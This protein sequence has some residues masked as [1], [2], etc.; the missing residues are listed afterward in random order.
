MTAMKTLRAVVVIAGVVVCSTVASADDN[1]KFSNK[2]LK[3]AYGFHV[4]GFLAANTASPIP[5]SAVGR[6]VYDGAGSC[7]SEAKLNA[8]GTVISLSGT[9][10]YTVNPDGTGTAVSTYS[11]GVFTTD[12]VLVDNAKEFHFIVSDTAQP[13]ATVGSGVAKRQK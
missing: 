5:A 4:H 12:F 2:S 11:F 10:T 1:G 7:T 8:G 6:N 13:G 9:C 3:G